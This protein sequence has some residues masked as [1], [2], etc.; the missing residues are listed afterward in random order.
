MIRVLVTAESA[1]ARAGLEA[2][3]QER[4]NFEVVGSARTLDEAAAGIQ[5][6]TPDVVVVDVSHDLPELAAAPLTATVLL[7]HDTQPEWIRDA[8]RSGVRAVLP[9]EASA[10][11]IAAAVEAVAAGLVVVDARDLEGVIGA[12]AAAPRGPALVE[13]QPLTAREIEV[14]R[15]IAE[16]D[17]NKAIAWKLGISEH[18]VKFHVASIMGKLGASSRTEAVSLGIRRGLILL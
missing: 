3:L 8:L 15:M 7:T 13:A 11:E 14:L 12:L 9:A 2:L 6:L 16:G 10:E 4:P 18:T 17:G 1:V 5:R